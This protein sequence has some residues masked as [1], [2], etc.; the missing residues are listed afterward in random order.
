MRI[1][2]KTFRGY[3]VNYIYVI[4]GMDRCSKTTAVNILRQNIK[5]PKLIVLHSAK[6][7]KG[8]DPEA[9]SI[10]HYDTVIDHIMELHDSGFDIILDRA[11]LGETVYG[12]LYRN[13]LIPIDRLEY[14]LDM[15]EEDLDKFKLLVLVDKPSSAITRDDGNSLS[16]NLDNMQKEY[17]LFTQAYELTKIKDKSI[18][19]WS[20]T[21]YSKDKLEKFIKEVLL[22]E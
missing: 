16:T 11:W 5:N 1:F 19:D 17:D 18:I 6:P 22:S 4:E 10:E 7:P 20:F 3:Q 15:F 2:L 8:V 9:W 21:T 12:P 14:Q 13:V